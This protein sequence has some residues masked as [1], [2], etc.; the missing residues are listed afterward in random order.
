MQYVESLASGCNKSGV[1]KDYEKLEP[2]REGGF[3]VKCPY[4]TLLTANVDVLRMRFPKGKTVCIKSLEEL[5][6]ELTPSLP[7]TRE[8]ERPK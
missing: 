1:C 6:P 5:V 7:E 4:L 3:Q 8:P 2:L